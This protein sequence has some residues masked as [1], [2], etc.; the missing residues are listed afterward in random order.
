MAADTVE[1]LLFRLHLNADEMNQQFVQVSRTLQDNLS[2][3]NRERNIVDIQT[4]IDL[5]GLDRATDA[6]QILKSDKEVCKDNWNFKGKG[7]T[8]SMSHLMTPDNVR[9]KPATKHNAPKFNTN[10]RGL[11]FAGLKRS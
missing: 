9:A 8:F 2:R 7:L 6:T 3:I 5:Q 4:R 10:K 11:Q 1:D